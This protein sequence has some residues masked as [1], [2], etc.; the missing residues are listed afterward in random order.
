MDYEDIVEGST[1]LKV[2]VGGGISKGEE[3]FYNPHMRLNRDITVALCRV[4]KP[5]TFIDLMAGSGA[6]G[7]RVAKEAGVDVTLNDLNPKALELIGENAALNGVQVS[8]ERQD[9]RA[10]LAGR[11]YDFFDLD[12]FGPPVPYAEAVVSQA[13]WGNYIGLCATDTSA[14]CG[15]Y[16]KA[17]MRKYDAVPLRCDC[18]NEV[19]LRVLIGFMARIALRHECGIEPLLCHST[20][21]YMRVQF[22]LGSRHQ[23]TMKSVGYMQYCFSC[24]RREYMSLCQLKEECSCGGK[25]QTAGPL[26]T[27]R[28]AD[29]Q[30]CKAVYDEILGGEFQEKAKSAKLLGLLI[31]EQEVTLPYYDLHKLCSSSGSDIPRTEKLAEA[32]SSAGYRF[33]RTHFKDVGFRT[34]MPHDELVRIL[35]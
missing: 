8:L 18:Y 11:K 5:K 27:G 4:L 21:H 17:C 33:A 6:R 32:V 12:P 29:E 16:P 3:V 22:R 31:K 34:D 35:K 25:F 1:R 14:L 28:F 24:L 26:W 30:I 2:P 7:V 13:R 9:A 20:R 19:G 10:I 23:E 15:S